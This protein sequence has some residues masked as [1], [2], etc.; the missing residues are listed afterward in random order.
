M[1]RKARPQRAGR[2]LSPSAPHDMVRIPGGT[3]RTGSDRDFYRDLDAASGR[4]N[5]VNRYTVTFAKGETPPVVQ[6]VD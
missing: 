2:V 4:L 5:G 6:K 1:L 3:F